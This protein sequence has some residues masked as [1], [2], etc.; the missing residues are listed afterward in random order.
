MHLQL[1]ILLNQI[2]EVGFELRGDGVSLACLSN[3]S[4]FL[5]QVDLALKLRGNDLDVRF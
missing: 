2:I 4:F 1:V 5:Q 3:K